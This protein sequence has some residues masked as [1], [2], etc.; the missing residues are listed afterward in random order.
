M[1]AYEFSRRE[2]ARFA[3]L[4]GHGDEFMVIET[5]TFE[6]RLS[7]NQGNLI[8]TARRVE[9][10]LGDDSRLTRNSKGDFDSELGMRRYFVVR[11]VP[12]RLR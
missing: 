4:D 11:E 7:V 9:Y 2:T 1:A 6:R 12:G 3:V 8:E 10:A 5:T